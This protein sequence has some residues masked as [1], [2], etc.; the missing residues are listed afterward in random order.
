[1]TQKDMSIVL[2]GVVLPSYS[3]LTELTKEN[4]T[5]RV[6]LGGSTFTDFKNVL[7]SWRMSWDLITEE[8][9]QII[10]G[11]YNNQIANK[12]YPFFE[13]AAFGLY[14]PVRMKITD[15]KYKYNGALIKNFSITITEQHAIS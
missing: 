12:S 9:Y 14:V 15:T 3:D 1:M 10:R 11:V 2:G 13:L 6:T 7:R 8:D 4:S 5:D